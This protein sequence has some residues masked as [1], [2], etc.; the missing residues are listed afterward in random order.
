[1]ISTLLAVLAVSPVAFK[2]GTPD[3]F[4]NF[5]AANSNQPV[6]IAVGKRETLKPMVLDFS[7]RNSLVQTV[8]E[9]QALKVRAGLDYVFSDNL[10]PVNLFPSLSSQTMRF[11]GNRRTAIQEPDAVS[12]GQVSN[13]DPSDT[14]PPAGEPKLPSDFLTKGMVTIDDPKSLPFSLNVLA[15]GTWSKKLTVFWLFDPV[16]L[17]IDV[18]NMPERQF[19]SLVAKTLGGQLAVTDTGYEIQPNWQVVQTELNTT[20]SSI[21]SRQ[22]KLSQ[23]ILLRHEL[24]ASSVQAMTSDEVADLFSVQG[25]YP[26]Y[27]I[28]PGSAVATVALNYI[29]DLASYEASQETRGP[30]TAVGILNRIDNR[31]AVRLHIT[32]TGNATLAVPAFNQRANRSTYIDL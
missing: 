4:L 1:M 7:N 17:Y 16:M 18:K 28:P 22:T 14:S 31:A 15:A 10:F 9:G 12:S 30:R 23:P 26:T 3:Q 8:N 5:V 29:N 21:L 2:G 20:F 24:F 27:D 32:N 11:V 19:L 6:I 13:S 25:K